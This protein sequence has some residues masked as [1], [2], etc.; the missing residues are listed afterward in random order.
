MTYF[1]SY[2]I[3]FLAVSRQFCTLNMITIDVTSIVKSNT[4]VY[5][6]LHYM[7]PYLYHYTVS[8]GLAHLRLA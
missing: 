2:C 6:S 7:N 3:L 8:Q 5:G 1:V 4:Y